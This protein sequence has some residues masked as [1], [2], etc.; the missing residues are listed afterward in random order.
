MQ[1]EKLKRVG[2]VRTHYSDGQQGL[3]LMSPTR[4]G[5]RISAFGVDYFRNGF[6]V[7][8]VRKDR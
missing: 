6:R 7:V 5:F 8:L 1:V 3:V 4:V 2:V